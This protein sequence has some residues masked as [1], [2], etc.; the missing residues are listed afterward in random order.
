MAVDV[1]GAQLA[2]TAMVVVVDDE[3]ESWRDTGGNTT[4]DDQ[5]RVDPAQ[6]PTNWGI[7]AENLCGRSW[8]S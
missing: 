4:Y 6:A 3:A 2:E 5:A 8:R 1:L 7:S